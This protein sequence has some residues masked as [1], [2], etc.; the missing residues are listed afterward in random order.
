MSKKIAMVVTTEH[1]GVFFGYAERTENK[2]IRLENARM[3]V[4]WPEKNRGVMGLAGS[5]PMSGARVTQAIPGITLHG[6]TAIMEVAP[7][8]VK[9]WESAPWS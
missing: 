9:A 3:C 5:G 4:H 2:I 6:I 7:E 8:A 1:K